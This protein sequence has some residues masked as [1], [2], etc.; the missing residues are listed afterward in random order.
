VCV[1]VI[2]VHGYIHICIYKKEPCSDKLTLLLILGDEVSTIQILGLGRCY[3]CFI[4]IYV[5]DLMAVHKNITPKLRY[6]KKIT[7]SLYR[8]VCMY[9]SYES[10]T[11]AHVSSKARAGSGRC[12]PNFLF[13][14][15]I[16]GF[17]LHLHSEMH[18]LANCL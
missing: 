18:V 12:S 16:W 15:C 3:N 8:Y 2:M 6:T 7:L 5:Q 4:Y 1:E 10:S 14:V 11:A 17:C 9:A 13:S